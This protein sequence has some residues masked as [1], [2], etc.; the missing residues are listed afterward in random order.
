MRNNTTN[1]KREAKMLEVIERIKEKKI[2]F[3]NS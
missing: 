1:V 2:T 3:T